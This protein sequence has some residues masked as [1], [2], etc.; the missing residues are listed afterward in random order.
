MLPPPHQEANSLRGYTCI[1]SASVLNSSMVWCYIIVDH[2]FMYFY[3]FLVLAM[4]TSY[5]VFNYTSRKYNNST[6]YNFTGN[7]QYFLYELFYVSSNS[8]VNVTHCVYNY[9][10][11]FIFA[12]LVV[13]YVCIIIFN[14]NN[15]VMRLP[16]T[17]P[18]F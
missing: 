7:L 14:F 13:S 5:C 4:V 8:F 10:T 3:I 2:K 9:I 16:I 12:L 1:R 18:L 17:V 15:D 11:S 6:K